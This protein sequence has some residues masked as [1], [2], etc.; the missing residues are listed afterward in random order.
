MQRGM[1]QVAEGV[2]PGSVPEDPEE[3]QARARIDTEK[4]GA[5]SRG[6]A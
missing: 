6:R 4:V 3:E 5:F 1:Q 2:D